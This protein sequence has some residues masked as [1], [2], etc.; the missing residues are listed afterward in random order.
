MRPAHGKRGRGGERERGLRT[1]D[2]TRRRIAKLLS[3][4]ST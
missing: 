4:G 2:V 3:T 1:I